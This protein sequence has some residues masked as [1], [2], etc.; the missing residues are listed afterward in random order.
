MAVLR[1]PIEQEDTQLRVSRN[2]EKGWL[3]ISGEVDSWN[4]GAV[5]EALQAALFE[6]GDIHIDVSHLLFC[7]VTGIRALVGAASH[8]T[9]GRRLIL[10]GLNPQLQRVVEVV[11]WGGM[12]SLVIEANGVDHG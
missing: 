9:D 12:P 5:R 6:K 8:L 2:R 4:V 10:H 11:G 3:R 1:L 7:D